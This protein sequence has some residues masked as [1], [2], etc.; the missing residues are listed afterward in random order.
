MNLIINKKGV[1]PP[2][3]LGGI[4][5]LYLKTQQK[6]DSLLNDKDKLDLSE[7][8]FEFFVL[9]KDNGLQINSVAEELGLTKKTIYN[10]IE[11]RSFPTK[12]TISNIQK[13]LASKQER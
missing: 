8:L 6:I 5:A 12:G 3:T 10:W 2:T 9:I 4:M 13:W 11:H 1:Y 7:T